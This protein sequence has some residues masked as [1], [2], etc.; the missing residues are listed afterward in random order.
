MSKSY[1]EIIKSHPDLDGVIDKKSWEYIGLSNKATLKLLTKQWKANMAKN[2]SRGLF[3]KHGSMARDCIGIGKNKALVGIGAGPGL[4]KNQH[5]LKQIHDYDGVK[6]GKERDF[7]FVASNHMFKPLLKEGIIPDFVAVGDASDVVM[8][9][10]TR[11]IPPSGQSVTLLAGLHCSPRVLKRWNAQGRDIR[12]YVTMTE[13]LP[14]Y[15]EE[16][17]G[18]NSKAVIVQQGGNI[19]NTMWSMGLKYFQ[20]STFMALGNDLSYPLAEDIEVRRKNYYADGDY[21]SNIGTKRDEASNV[22]EGN[23]QAWRGIKLERSRIL[24]ADAT[25]RYNI[26]LEHVLTTGTLWVYKT[27]I[28]SNVLANAKTSP[29]AYHYYNCT[30]SGIAGVMCKAKKKKEFEDLNNW[31]LMDQVCKRWKTR[32]FS[33]AIEEFQTAKRMLK[34]GPSLN[35]S[36][37]PA[38]IA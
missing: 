32:M 1:E 13:E 27:W 10:L 25:K 38:A 6:A 26:E 31:F 34:W 37:V 8:D 33:D 7:V 15:F 2:V 28:E 23:L 20:S 4:K 12:F 24:S 35:R 14:E 30:E 11:D 19:L 3:K 17:T 29:V 5:I 9:Q 18:G 22:Y 36:V 21:T 16:L